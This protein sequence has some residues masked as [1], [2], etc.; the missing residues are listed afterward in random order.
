MNEPL[1][2]AWDD[3]VLVGIIARTQ[4]LRG[5]VFVNALTDF[6]DERFKAGATVWGRIAGVVT[7]LQIESLRIQGG[8][9]VVT[10]AGYGDVDRA[11]AR[12]KNGVVIVKLPKATARSGSRRIPISA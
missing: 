3:M 7:P 11:E 8:R 2:A 10:F 12:V 6:A 9:P 5:H 1:N 4:G